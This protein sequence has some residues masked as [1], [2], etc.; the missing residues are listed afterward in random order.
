MWQFVFALCHRLKL[1]H[2]PKGC[3]MVMA[4]PSD[5]GQGKI[6]LVATLVAN[7]YHNF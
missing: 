2:T 5:L 4:D 7:P 6:D 3:V 1:N